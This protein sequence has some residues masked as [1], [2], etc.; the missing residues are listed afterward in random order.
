MGYARFKLWC[1]G[2][3]VSL[4]LA[5]VLLMA[6]TVPLDDD[7]PRQG[8]MWNRTGL[9]AVFP[10]HVKTTIGEDYVLLLSDPQTG[11]DVLAAFIVGGRFFRVLVPP[12]TFRVRFAAGV[13]WQGADTMFGRA[14]QTRIIEMPELLTFEV[15]GLRTKSG[16]LIDLT[17]SSVG[18]LA[19]R[20]P[21]RGQL[22]PPVSRLETRG[23][24]AV[25]PS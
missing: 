22:V 11:A 9:P 19:L 17:N 21:L 4:F 18:E 24:I 14:G 20:L 10:L 7:K 5:P 25:A 2:A 15:K 12:G 1:C 16:H 13:T 8:L 3:L 23:R 6:Q